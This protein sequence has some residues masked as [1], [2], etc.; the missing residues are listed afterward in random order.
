[1]SLDITKNILFVNHQ[2]L[3]GSVFFLLNFYSTPAIHLT[4]THDQQK[5]N[6]FIIKT[7][8]VYNAFFL[9]HY[10]RDL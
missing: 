1:M 8:N 6:I 5:I 4:A 10:H 7:K 9:L 3:V 2:L